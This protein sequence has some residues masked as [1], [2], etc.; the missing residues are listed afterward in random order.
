M[1][2]KDQRNSFMPADRTASLSKLT[3]CEQ[4][5]FLAISVI[6]I[7]ANPTLVLFRSVSRCVAMARYRLRRDGLVH[8]GNAD[9]PRHPTGKPTLYGCLY[10]FVIG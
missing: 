10:K 5:L 7:S 4:P 2:Q 9:G 3:V 1:L 6:S 8:G